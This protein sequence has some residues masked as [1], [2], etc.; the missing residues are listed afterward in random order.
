LT[1]SDPFGAF[2]NDSVLL[3]VH[4][5][6]APHASAGFDQL[7]NIDEIV[8]F[9]PTS[10]YDEDGDELDFI[11]DFDSSDGIT[12]DFK[13]VDATHIYEKAGE[14]TVTLHVTDSRGASSADTIIVTVNTP[15]SA[16][17]D[18]E[19]SALIA[20]E[21]SFSATRSSDADSDLLTFF[22]DFDEADGTDDID[23]QG[24][25]V[26]HVFDIGGTYKVTLTVEDGRKG[27]T[28]ASAEIKITDPRP[29]DPPVITSPLN[30]DEVKGTL[31]IEGVT[32]QPD[33]IT[34]IELRIDQG[35]W[36]EVK[37]S[38]NGWQIWRYVLDTLT[39]DDGIHT[40]SVRAHTYEIVSAE[41]SLQIEILNHDNEVTN[42][43]E[44]EDLSSDDGEGFGFILDP[45]LD[46]WKRSDTGFFGTF[47]LLL[48]V[49]MVMLAIR[50]R[51]VKKRSLFQ[52]PKSYHVQE[53]EEELDDEEHD[54]ERTED[55]PEAI[56]LK[57]KDVE[58]MLQC[59]I[60]QK[61]FTVM[62]MTEDVDVSCPFC[63][64]G[65]KLEG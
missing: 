39:I 32:T 8:R 9:D 3:T 45:F 6:H 34:R 50:K 28:T 20:E 29:L 42:T 49:L 55:I 57:E 54:K 60:C 63:G 21:V 30:G 44:P 1:V 58:V 61:D 48:V 46:L 40:I 11:W 41:S 37:P 43:D 12:Q 62:G 14:Y 13:G 35:L 22:W 7:V 15:P 36:M 24:V 10:T 26:V 23:A 53:L 52:N 64:V 18:S 4:N 59:P 17:M 38:T 33:R 51:R 47:A 56:I 31:R 65:G 16:I 19:S 27:T 2:S 5:N 25:D